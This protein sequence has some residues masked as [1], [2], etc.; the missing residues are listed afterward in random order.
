RTLQGVNSGSVVAGVALTLAAPTTSNISGNGFEWQ[1][2][3]LNADG[4]TLTNQGVF[5]LTG[6]NRSV[7]GGIVNDGAMVETSDY[8]RAFSNAWLL[9]NGSLELRTSNWQPAAGASGEFMNAGAVLKTTAATAD[10]WLDTV[11]HGSWDIQSGVLRLRYLTL[12]SSDGSGYT[13][14][15]GAALVLEGDTL[16]GVIKGENSGVFL[17]S[18]GMTLANPVTL[19][20]SGNGVEWQSG[21]LEASGGPL[22]NAGLLT[23]T[24]GSRAVLGDIVN[25]GALIETSDYLR[26]FSGA[27]ITSSGTLELR[28]CYWAPASPSSA[29]FTN[30]GLLRK[31]TA[32]SA[33][34]WLDTVNN[35]PWNIEAG[36]LIHRGATLDSSPGA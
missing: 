21:D 29:T 10:L 17:I 34:F 35:G 15:N 23:L 19:D 14:A 9:N 16:A 6:G 4:K 13:I 32:A 20:I 28:T 12:D 8:L 11:S 5:F 33:E 2:G 7:F 30:T 22:T 18:G 1:G 31:T 27:L 36:S 24:G 3:N 25:Q 26:S